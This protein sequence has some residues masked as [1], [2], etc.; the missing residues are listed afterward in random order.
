MLPRVSFHLIRYV[1][2][3]NHLKIIQLFNHLI[4]QLFNYSII[5]LKII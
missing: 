4:I 5:H 1:L 2:K 3:I